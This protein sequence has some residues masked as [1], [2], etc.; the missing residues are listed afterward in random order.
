LESGFGGRA[1]LAVLT[2]YNPVPLM[3]LHYPYFSFTFF[4]F[5]PFALSSLVTAMGPEERCNLLQRGL[6]RSPSGNWIWMHFKCNADYLFFSLHH[7]S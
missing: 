6:W 4:P 7:T 3:P 1:T 2:P 5:L